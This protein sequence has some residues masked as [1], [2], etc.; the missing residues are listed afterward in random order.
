MSKKKT[1]NKPVTKN[2]IISH[3]S[4]ALE[5]SFSLAREMCHFS[6]LYVNHIPIKLEEKKKKTAIMSQ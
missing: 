5:N 6:N 2:S 3:H 4:V 1:F